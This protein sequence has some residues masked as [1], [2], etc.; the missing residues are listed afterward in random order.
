MGAR[1]EVTPLRLVLD[2]NVVLSALLFSRGRLEWLRLSWQAGE[3]L[4]LI[5]R[6]TVEELLRVLNYPRFQLEIAE[7]E[8]LLAEYLPWCE[9]VI[10]PNPLP[11]LPECRDPFDLKFLELALAAG[12][13]G[14]VTGDAD[15]LV[16]AET[17]SVAIITPVQLAQRLGR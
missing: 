11:P 14:L 6:E 12:A 10:V 3:V 2:T 9:T 17:F 15:L 1:Q 16:L 7:Q 8:V 5:S 13:D 4:P